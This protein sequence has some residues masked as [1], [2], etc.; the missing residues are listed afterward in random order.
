MSNKVRLVD[1]VGATQ[2]HID[3]EITE[4]GDLLFSGQD[5]GEAPQQF[6]DDSDYEYWLRISAADK[7]RVLLALI[8]KLYSG[9]PSVVSE[10]KEFLNSRAIPCTFDSY[11]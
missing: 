11:S 7:D 9:N 10:V 8:D 1:I 6:F 5:L 3:V 2:I 4:E